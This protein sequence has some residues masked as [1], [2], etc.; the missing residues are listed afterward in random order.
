VCDLK[1]IC[2]FL[3]KKPMNTFRFQRRRERSGVRKKREA[4]RRTATGRRD[5]KIR[6]W[7][8][9]QTD[10]QTDRQRQRKSAARKER[11]QSEIR[12]RD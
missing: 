5:G 9:N 6:K 12:Q 4:R 10:R 1:G 2:F 11:L 3:Q 7:T 8:D